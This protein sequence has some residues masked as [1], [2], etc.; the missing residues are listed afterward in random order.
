MEAAFFPSNI[1]Y[2]SR[3]HRGSSARSMEQPTRNQCVSDWIKFNLGQ[4]SKSEKTVYT[5]IWRLG[6][7][8]ARGFG[9]V[10]DQSDLDDCIHDVMVRIC[11]DEKILDYKYP[12]AYFT[13]SVKHTCLS[14]LRSRRSDRHEQPPE[15]Q[16]G[17][18]W[19]SSL[20]AEEA[21]LD[22]LFEHAQCM[23]EVLSRLNSEQKNNLALALDVRVHGLAA[24]EV[25]ALSGRSARAVTQAVSNFVNVT[26][27]NMIEEVCPGMV[28]QVTGRLG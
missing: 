21:T 12:A 17:E 28:Q 19:E 26:L 23:Q 2:A 25:A 4:S 16:D 8:V 11:R 9:N 22:L 7:S 15:F 20:V 3:R 18:A 1:W 14:R 13:R 5:Q 10:L 6:A 27:R 24:Q